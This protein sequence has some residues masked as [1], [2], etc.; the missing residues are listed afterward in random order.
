MSAEH[1][2]TAPN[3]IPFY[4]LSPGGNTT[5]LLPASAV[6]AP[7]RAAVAAELMNS[8]HL[9]AEQVGFIDL[10]ANPPSLNMMGGEFC[11]NACRCLAALL[12]MFADEKTQKTEIQPAEGHLTSSGASAPVAWRVRPLAEGV[13]GLDA[14]VR[15]D[16]NGVKL[17]ELDPGITRVDMPG[18]VHI[19]LDESRYPAPADLAAE[20]ADWRAKLNIA[21]LPAA[22]CIRHPPLK[23][24]QQS[25]L[26]LIWVR[27]TNSSCPETA[28]GSGS[29]ALALALHA[30][31]D[32][33]S[34]PIRQPSGEDIIVTLE[35]GPH[36]IQSGW[37]GGPVRLI[38]QGRVFS[39]ALS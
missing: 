29:L 5:L 10:D 36:G 34:I 28:C 23:A 25:I 27:A 1:S 14:A 21:D 17:T 39:R 6:P 11:G 7:Q 33:H 19:L 16:L 4:K 30:A 20:A 2:P 13:P 3:G 24:E 26:P 32:R 31:T 37:I 35:L 38:A 12:A 18:M 9:G 15:I 22:G 8:L